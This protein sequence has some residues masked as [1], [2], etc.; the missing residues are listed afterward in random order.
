MLHYKNYKEK[1]RNNNGC[2]GAGGSPKAPSAG[3][4]QTV[5][6]VSFE[7]VH[8]RTYR[9]YFCMTSSRGRRPSLRKM[10]GFHMAARAT[11]TEEAAVACRKSS[12]SKYSW[13][14]S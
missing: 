1:E 10:D 13:M 6:N 9:M 12:M 3:M 2:W 5:K 14:W 8:R 7:K 11:I 4:W